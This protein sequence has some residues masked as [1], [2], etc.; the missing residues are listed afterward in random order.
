MRHYQQGDDTV[1]RYGSNHSRRAFV[2]GL[3]GV[4]LTCE[5]IRV[6]TLYLLKAHQEG[7]GSA[8]DWSRQAALKAA[9]GGVY[10]LYSARIISSKTTKRLLQRISMHLLGDCGF[11]RRGVADA[12]L[13]HARSNLVPVVGMLLA[14]DELVMVSTSAVADYAEPVCDA[15]GIQH[16]CATPRADRDGWFHNVGR[17][18]TWNT[19][20][21]IRDAGGGPDCT[22]VFAGGFDDLPLMTLGETVC[23]FGGAEEAETLRQVLR[24]DITII[25]ARD[26]TADALADRLGI[27]AEDETWRPTMP[28]LP[29]RRP[30]HESG[31]VVVGFPTLPGRQAF[32]NPRARSGPP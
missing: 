3:D 15:L 23:W 22:V 6:W 2:L 9:V 25:E 17:R 4:L 26:M 8:V 13:S 31:H 19:L 32:S 5:S 1:S 28:G 10:G 11:H 14:R 30:A 16:I 7:G 18:K 21:H 27:R 29:R 12:L 24:D 20:D